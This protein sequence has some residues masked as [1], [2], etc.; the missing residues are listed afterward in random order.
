MTHHN[1]NNKGYFYHIRKP[2]RQIT[3]HSPLREISQVLEWRDLPGKFRGHRRDTWIPS[4]R[5]RKWAPSPSSSSSS[6][7]TNRSGPTDHPTYKRTEGK[8]GI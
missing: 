2:G 1:H 8:D 6:T 7:R 4:R 5:S 3:V